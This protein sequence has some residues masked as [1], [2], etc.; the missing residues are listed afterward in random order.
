MIL[1]YFVLIPLTAGILITLFC[2][3]GKRLAAYTGVLASA[4]LLTLA[5][6][7]FILVSKAHGPILFTLGNWKI[8]WTIGFVIDY[9]A[10]FSL[11]A[12]NLIALAALFFSIGYMN[13]YTGLWKFYA[14]LMIML[15]GINGFIITGD[16]FNLF[17]FLEITLLAAYALVGF[18]CEAEELEAAFKYAVIGS[19]SSIFILL[20][21]GV[22]YAMTSTLNMA[23]LGRSIT[24]SH[25]FLIHFIYGLLLVGFGLKVALVPFH[26]WMP[27]AYS[28]APAPASAI[29]SGV[30]GVLGVYALIRLFFNVFPSSPAVLNIFL[31]LGTISIFVGIFVAKM[32]FDFKRLLAYSSIS[33]IGYIILGL[34]LGTPLGVLGAVFHMINH[35]F[36]KSLLFLNAGSIEYATGTRDFREMN[37]IHKKLK[38]TA[39]TS[40]IASL[41][42]SGIPPFN[43]FF[44][45]LV[46][47][48]AAVQAHQ[49]VYAVLAAVASALTL[50]VFLKVQKHLTQDSGPNEIQAK[51]VKV[52]LSLNTAMIFLAVLCILSAVLILPGIKGLVLDKV[53]GTIQN[54]PA[55]LNIIPEV[56][57]EAAT[58]K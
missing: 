40:M 29:L 13:H 27:D 50:A 20:A 23:D 31:I 38:P 41:S 55:Y 42:I 12:V 9:L 1:P 22:L 49:P 53:V 48:L 10:S 54:R 14:L 47:I 19:L 21:I 26:T 43:G 51:P 15:T 44:S 3:N 32:Q 25:G 30:S 28:A 6:T 37:G 46:I 39:V 34:G 52:P 58:D 36:M 33:Q 18:G 57:H 17:I 24:A 4:A 16:F 8:P 7:S 56:S 35:G 11:I 5:I 2:R 45:K